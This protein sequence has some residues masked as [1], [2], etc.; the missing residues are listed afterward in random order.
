MVK[1]PSSPGRFE[2]KSPKIRDVICASNPP[3]DDGL[4]Y[5][6]I[7]P[8]HFRQQPRTREVPVSNDSQ[9]RNV[10][11]FGGLLDG[12]T[13][14]RLATVGPEPFDRRRSMPEEVVSRP[15]ARVS[16]CEYRVRIWISN[17]K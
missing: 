4:L 12:K 6:R 15:S 5:V 11:N 17:S 8:A 7:F 13:S 10:Q 1:H 2:R 14:K 3:I 9:T 16:S